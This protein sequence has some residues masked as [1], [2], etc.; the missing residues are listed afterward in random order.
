MDTGSVQ[1]I[2][3]VGTQGRG[4]GEPQ[5]VT[6]YTVSV[7]S[8]GSSFTAVDGG[9]VFT[10]NV[11]NSNYVVRNNFAAVVTARYLRIEPQTWEQ[12]MSMRAGVYLYL[13]ATLPSSPDP[14][15]PSSVPCMPV[16]AIEPAVSNL[17]SN[18][19]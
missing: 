4:D 5:W 7:S 11:D 9:N 18:W 1:D 12:H 14:C 2:Q 19:P 17:C 8:D 3:G 10:G 6:T 15:P 16:P 13:G